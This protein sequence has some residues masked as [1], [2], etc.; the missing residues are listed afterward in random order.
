MSSVVELERASDSGRRPLA[1][2]TGDTGAFLATSWGRRP[3]LHEGDEP[4]GFGD[5]LSL[6]EVDR[7]LS[8]TSLRTPSFRLVKAGEQIPESA[9]TRS[10][11]TGSRPVSGMADPARVFGLFEQGATIVLQGLHRYHEPVTRFCRDLEVELGHPCQANAYITPPGAQGLE[12]HDDPHDVFVLQAFGTK[13]WEVHE[14][15][16]EPEREPIRA[17]IAPGDCI[18]MPTG[19]PHAASTQRSLSGHLTIGVHVVAWRDVLR[20][21]IKALESDPSLAGSIPA[22]W[23]SDPEAFDR[24][25]RE[26]LARAGSSLSALDT[27]AIVGERLERFLS[28]RLPL[29][30]GGLADRGALGD[31]GDDTRLGRREGS[32]LVLR[33]RDDRLIALLGDR[34]LEMPAWLEPAMRHIADAPSFRLGE[35]SNVVPDR[36]SRAVLARRL[37]REGLLRPIA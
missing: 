8:T 14:A 30:R 32:I 36:D 23:T 4:A 16:G 33:T 9:Y 6:D 26:R 24:E 15:P 17:E 25:L 37:V 27:R 7:I 13:S 20:D 22:G 29:L 21:A 10:G 19:T 34:R 1:R 28:T 12:L 18:Y 2:C 31:I 11:T 5:L 35:L 3:S